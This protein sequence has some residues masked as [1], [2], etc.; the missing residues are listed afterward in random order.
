MFCLQTALSI[1]IYRIIYFGS[2]ATA[3]RLSEQVR[4]YCIGG[5]DECLK[6]RTDWDK[7]VY[8]LHFHPYTLFLSSPVG[9]QA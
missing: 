7:F 1:Y 4:A 9:S 5:G 8:Y 3:C 6:S 2:A